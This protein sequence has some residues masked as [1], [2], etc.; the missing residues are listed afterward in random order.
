MQKQ[1]DYNTI[2][3]IFRRFRASE[4]NP[5]GELDHVNV[6][7]LVVAVAL[8]AQATDKGVNLATRELFKI[9][10]TPQKMVDLGEAGL[11]K[12]IKSIGLFRNKAKNVIKLS[13]MLIDVY[14]SEVPSSRA[15]L[16]TLP[17]VGRKTANVVL[18]M[19]F[20]YPAQAVDTHIFRLGNRTGIA[21]GK[22]VDAVE[23]AI[24]DNIPVEFQQHAHHWM[25]L[26][27]RYVCKARKP[28]C[29]NCII[30]EFCDSEEKTL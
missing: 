22:N 6:F 18:N 15:A 5:K 19:W 27:G 20:H 21:P 4:A 9:A 23:R 24:E 25:I 26:H 12:H 17:G 8:S 30:A 10:D 14:G 7:T 29:P 3:E 16:I 13:Q 11:I 2:S 1:L 28:V